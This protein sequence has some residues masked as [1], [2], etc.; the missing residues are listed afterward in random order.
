MNATEE[1]I[2]RALFRE[3]FRGCSMTFEEAL[4]H[5]RGEPIAV[6][7]A[8]LPAYARAVCVALDKI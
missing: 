8:D 1:E 5:S 7:G 6:Y 3:I 2:A 4:K